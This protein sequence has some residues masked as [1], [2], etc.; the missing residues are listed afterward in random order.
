MVVKE[1]FTQ[2]LG[3]VTEKLMLMR[4]VNGA[5]RTLGQVDIKK[6]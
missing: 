5:D 3:K 4:Y 2:Y 6:K 1:I